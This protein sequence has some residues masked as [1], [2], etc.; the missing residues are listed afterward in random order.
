LTADACLLWYS[1]SRRGRC[2]LFT[3]ILDSL[4]APC[5]VYNTAMSTVGLYGRCGQYGRCMFIR[6]PVRPVRGLYEPTQVY[7]AYCYRPNSVVCL[8]VCY[9]S[10]PC[11]TAALIEMPF[12][13]R[14]RVGLGNA[15]NTCLMGSRS[16]IKFLRRMASSCKVYERFAVCCAK[17]G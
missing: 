17:N 2:G 3:D 6:W 9:T 7:A 4:T 12:G 8:S 1:G 11:K 14:I 5:L 13:L 15:S 10:E 16:S